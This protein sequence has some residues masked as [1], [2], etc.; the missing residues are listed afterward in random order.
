MY[1]LLDEDLEDIICYV[2]PGDNPNKQW[3]IALPQ[4]MLEKTVKWFN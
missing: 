1:K 2:N 3:H 4:Q